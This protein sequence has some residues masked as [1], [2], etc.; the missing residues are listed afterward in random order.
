MN[1]DRRRVYVTGAG[2]VS[3]CGIGM[4]PFWQTIRENRSGIGP[5]SFD[6][7]ARNTVL[8]GGAVRE[9]N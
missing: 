1:G 5:L 9:F 7:P 6:R 4:E 8:I 3:A 2:V